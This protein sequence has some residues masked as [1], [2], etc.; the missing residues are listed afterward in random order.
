MGP[1]PAVATVRSA[2]RSAL[3]GL[4]EGSLV[5]AAVS[6]GADSLALLAGLTFEAPRAGLRAGAVHVDHG[7]APGSADVAT[8]VA[9][10]ARELGADP[11]EICHVTVGT[12]GGP[13]AAARSAR[14]AALDDVADRVGAAAVLTGHTRDDQA[15]S[16]LLG[17]VRG[18]G[19][20]SLAGIPPVRGRYRR[21]LLDLPRATTV[22]ACAA[23][24]LAVWDDPANADVALR[25]NVVRHDVLPY[26]AERLGPGV[27]SGLARSAALLRADDEA[28]EELA[29]GCLRAVTLPAGDG[30]LLALAADGLAGC[31]TA[32]R[33]RVL[34]RACVTAGVPGGS[35]GSVHVDAL[36]ALVMAWHGQ[37]EVGLPG[38]F[39]GARRS[40]R[41]VLTRPTR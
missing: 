22:A 39:A 10:G 2:V 4:P 18:S 25:R 11:M 17:L 21:P 15:E 37:G 14:Y 30:E 41:V 35:L 40:G 24:G 38:G 36:E 9:A 28:L 19:A 3:A 13:E 5:L 16:V 12:A 33:R 29:T 32:V 8:R 7:I 1:D 6:G 31:S 26:L 20:R 23:L 34:H 27:V